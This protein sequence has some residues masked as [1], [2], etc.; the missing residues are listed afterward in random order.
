[1]RSSDG[2]PLDDYIINA[3]D[4]IPL[5]AQ[6]GK[7][8]N[9]VYSGS[10]H[11]SHSLILDEHK[12]IIYD[13]GGHNLV[14]IML[15]KG[16]SFSNV[17]IRKPLNADLDRYLIY[18]VKEVSIGILRKVLLEFRFGG[19]YFNS[20]VQFLFKESTGKEIV[21]KERQN[22]ADWVTNCYFGQTRPS[23]EEFYQEFIAGKKTWVES[24]NPAKRLHK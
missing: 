1:M 8:A 19:F 10:G 11:D 24:V 22:L 2:G 17:C 4:N 12:N 15:P 7:G 23:V 6:M 18:R 13:K 14:A 5:M 9:R 3:H 16:V 21:F 20:F